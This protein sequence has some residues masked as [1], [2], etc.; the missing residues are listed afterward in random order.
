MLRIKSHQKWD[1]HV[2]RSIVFQHNFL[3]HLQKK[4]LHQIWKAQFLLGYFSFLMGLIYGRFYIKNIMST[5]TWIYWVLES[6]K[7]LLLK[8]HSGVGKKK[9]KA[10][11]YISLF[12]KIRS[13]FPWMAVKIVTWNSTICYILYSKWFKK[14]KTLF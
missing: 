11:S 9:K 14:I 4:I 6:K 7:Q 3:W 2:N 8:L 1:G 12:F 10:G 13:L 5:F